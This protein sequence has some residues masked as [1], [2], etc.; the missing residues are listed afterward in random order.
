MKIIKNAMQSKLATINTAIENAP[1]S[2]LFASDIGLN[3]KMERYYLAAAAGECT[4]IAYD[5]A[6]TAKAFI[7]LMAVIAENG[8]DYTYQPLLGISD[9]LKGCKALVYT[10]NGITPTD[11]ATA[12]VVRPISESL[13][14]D[15]L[16]DNI[17]TDIQDTEAKIVIIDDMTGYA[18]QNCRQILI[19]LDGLA[20]KHGIVL[21]A[22]FM[23]N[24]EAKDVNNYFATHTNGL[25]Q[26]TSGS[27]NMSNE[28]QEKQQPYFCFSYGHPTPKRIYYGIDDEGKAC[29]V[30]DLAK[31]LRIRELAKKYAPKWIALKQFKDICF[32]ALA[33][34]F[35]KSSLEKAV[36][37][38]A[39]YGFIQVSGSKTK[40]KICYISG[41]MSRNTCANNIA[42]TAKGNP[43]KGESKKHPKKRKPILRHGEF[44]LIAP[45]KGLS[46]RIVFNF[47]VDLIGAI[48][49]GKKWLD[50]DVKT[51]YRNTLAILVGSTQEDVER[52]TKYISD[53][54]E[55]AKFDAMALP[56]GITDES[57]L[58][59]YKKAINDKKP[60][61]IFVF[62][63]N[64]IG[65]S[66]YTPAQQVKELATFSKKKG[67]C[68]IAMSE[69]HI[70][71]IDYDL[72]DEF[73]K[74]SPLIDKDTWEDMMH[75][76]LI[77]IPYIYN[78]QASVS[79]FDFLCRFKQSRQCA[80]F[81]FKDVKAEEQQLA[82][83]M[84]TFYW[85]NKTD[86]YDIDD[87][88]GND[89]TNNVIYQAKQL[90]LIKVEYTSDKKKLLE[91]RITFLGK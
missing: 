50:F 88:T 25:C 3:V 58:T 65:Q 67:V 77:G 90:G 27:L 60:D 2:G 28:I 30:R 33:G 74:I 45:E 29:I 51:R 11:E 22:G 55:G 56:E 18:K 26:L 91:S 81:W 84:G 4:P 85:C 39:D 68:T 24:D 6:D 57:F 17:D 80:P 40:T 7:S 69:E 34:E 31:L 38:A 12:I 86:C 35:E 20:Y 53:F 75:Y 43:Y 41:N 62:F 42:L 14:F 1:C 23:L 47:T 63:Y 61:F 82:F 48:L 78:L 72:G 21:L 10:L 76:H 13:P 8:Q 15:E 70:D 87:C 52:L 16:I 32:G 54:G 36:S 49:T 89:L 64:R 71:M 79:G 19:A 83:L 37:V 5:D 66:I 73:W 9:E 59:A 44:K 46:K